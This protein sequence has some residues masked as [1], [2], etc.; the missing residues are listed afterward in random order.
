MAGLRILLVALALFVLQVAALGIDV[1]NSPFGSIYTQWRGNTA[2]ASNESVD[3]T[4]TA[5]P[6]VTL[7]AEVA[8]VGGTHRLVDSPLT[9]TLFG[10]P[11][12]GASLVSYDANGVLTQEA[13]QCF[14]PFLNAFQPFTISINKLANSWTIRVSQDS[15]SVTW[16]FPFAVSPP[17]ADA[18]NVILF[19]TTQLTYINLV[20][21]GLE[22][23]AS[24][25]LT[26]FNPGDKMTLNLTNN[27]VEFAI[28]G[29]FGG[30]VK[31][32]PLYVTVGANYV[33]FALYDNTGL[34][35][36]LSARNPIPFLAV[37]SWYLVHVT[38][39]SG[40]WYVTVEQNYTQHNIN[41]FSWPFFTNVPITLAQNLGFKSLLL[42]SITFTQASA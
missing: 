5:V 26:A 30:T 1:N 22:Q 39:D 36:V 4:L 18:L 28:G 21:D 42:N 16:L 27:F 2:T 38:R 24:Y 17:I 3:V 40:Y 20:P 29:V 15:Y 23:F 10:G 25:P 12:A 41:T 31:N 7:F 19:G 6:N 11:N 14:P 33:E 37:Q 13:S 9:V 8:I 34:P 32:M 35:L